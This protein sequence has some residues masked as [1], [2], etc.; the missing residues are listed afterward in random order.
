MSGAAET[1]AELCRQ[2]IP[3]GVLSNS[4]YR[5]AVLT[6]ELEKQ[7]L[8]EHLQFVMSSAEHGIRKPDPL[9]FELAAK[10]LGRK[11]D[12]IW[13]VGDKAEIDVNGAKSAGMIPVWFQP[14]A[15][16]PLPCAGITGWHEFLSLFLNG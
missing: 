8:A 14:D 7:G 15:T 3:V 12:D 2:N 16:S 9:L 13:F 10:K 1:L 6:Y 11:S 4:I 5:P